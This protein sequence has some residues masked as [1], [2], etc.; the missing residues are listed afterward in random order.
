MRVS[1]LRIAALGLLMAM[2]PIQVRL[3]SADDDHPCNQVLV[4]VLSEENIAACT[5]EINSGLLQGADL[6]TAY[7]N[8]GVAY[9]TAH[10]VDRAFDDYSEAIRL[11]PKNT[12]AYTGRGG[13]YLR[14]GDVDHA[15]ADYNEVIQID[16]GL[17]FGFYNRGN[18]YAV[19]SDFDRA[20]SDL[21]EAIRLDPRFTLA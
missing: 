16:P 20:I 18:A 2:C 11:D 17:A 3:A 8:R 1:G 15:I 19:M 5:R 21:D 14:K 7:L 6:A 9:A 13:L 12:T 10:D 4:Q